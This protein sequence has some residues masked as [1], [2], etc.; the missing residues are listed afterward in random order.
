[1]ENLDYDH[2]SKIDSKD[3]WTSINDLV[4]ALEKYTGELNLKMVPEKS[5]S[6]H[7]SIQSILFYELKQLLSLQQRFLE[8][9][10][11]FRMPTDSSRTRLSRGSLDQT[12]SDHKKI[13]KSVMEW[14]KTAAEKYGVSIDSNYLLPSEHPESHKLDF[15][16]EKIKS[17]LFV[18][19]QRDISNAME[20][21]EKTLDALMESFIDKAATVENLKR[22]ETNLEEIILS[23]KKSVKSKTEAVES[24][25]NTMQTI[26]PPDKI[27]IH[28]EL[29]DDINHTKDLHQEEISN[30][31]STI[32]SLEIKLSEQEYKI[33][34]LSLQISSS[35][36]PS[37][38][39][40]IQV[41]TDY[42]TPGGSVLQ[43]L[44]SAPSVGLKSGTTCD[45]IQSY[46]HNINYFI[47][48][49]RLKP[50]PATLYLIS[51][52]LCSKLVADYEDCLNRRPLSSLRNFVLQYFLKNFGCRRIA[53]IL[54]KDFFYSMHH[55]FQQS[56]RI[57]M[58]LSMCEANSLKLKLNVDMQ[59]YLHKN[60][61]YFKIYGLPTVTALFIE[62]AFMIKKLK[63]Y[64]SAYFMPNHDSNNSF[65]LKA[66]DAREVCLK[67]LKKY[68]FSEEKVVNF[69]ANFERVV[70][71]DLAIRIVHGKATRPDESESNQFIS[72]DSVMELIIFEYVNAYRDNLV[73]FIANLRMSGVSK[74]DSRKCLPNM[75]YAVN[76]S[77]LLARQSEDVQV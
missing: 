54:L 20:K 63:G 6:S 23:L 15:E 66:E 62:A 18:N 72:Y 27:K 71:T 64:D 32:S 61:L 60:R 12:T 29:E 21:L 14:F 53:L 52:I 26:K 56:V 25:I 2:F 11:T 17:M 22:K 44:N 24:A 45:D 10:S 34:Q 68:K 70:K 36:K 47:V 65:L 5:Q 41:T 77:L 9:A 74:Y 73:S 67:I 46:L 42:S 43:P 16:M 69:V 51:D 75:I 55:L 1:M 30:L 38:H 7:S 4:Q 40:C 19:N 13:M 8:T 3:G 57:E 49:G 35:K 28:K 39:K 59:E 58:F 37:E 31:L 48:G 33:Q 76:Y 50:L